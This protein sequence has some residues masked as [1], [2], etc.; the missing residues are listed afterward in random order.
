M[1]NKEIT[2]II[3]QLR[4]ML[5]KEKSY[6]KTLDVSYKLPEVKGPKAQI[7]FSEVAGKKMEALIKE[8][9]KE[10]GWH[11]TVVRDQKHANIFYINDIFVFPQKVTSVTVTPDA[12]E[13]AQ[14]L[15]ELSNE[16]F[17]QL[18]FH[19]HSHVNMPTSPSGTDTTYQSN[20]LN[21]L[22]D[23]YI[24]GIFNKKSDSWMKILDVTNN[25]IYDDADIEYE[26]E[27]DDVTVWA[28][29]QVKEYVTTETTTVAAKFTKAYGTPAEKEKKEKQ[30]SARDYYNSR[31]GIPKDEDGFSYYDDY[32]YGRGIY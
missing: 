32:Y 30:Q 9:S 24:F 23:F 12:T 16:E 28:E 27:V 26:V 14:W 3:A 8:C 2:S 5:K 31:Y 15:G 29:E 13:Y 21:N 4:D 18:R 25:I 7:I 20:I 22:E 11:G 6:D 19:G 17:A 1:T 10:V